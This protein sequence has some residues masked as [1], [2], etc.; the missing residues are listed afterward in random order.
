MQK[1]KPQGTKII[2][3]TILEEE[4]KTKAGIIAVDYALE[5]GEIVEVGTDVEHLYKV[6]DIVL[7]PEGSGHSLNYQK[8]S[9]KWL[10]GRSF[11]SG[12]I[13]SLVYEETT[14]KND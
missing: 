1:L 12:D 6:G 9:C 7:F 10:D 2:I 8:K 5:T 3:Q 11:P 14:K 13:W 4:K